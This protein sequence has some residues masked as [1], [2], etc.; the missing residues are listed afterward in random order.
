[1]RFKWETS[2]PF[3]MAALEA[4]IQ[5]R[6]LGFWMAGSGPAMTKVENT[7]Q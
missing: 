6:K 5:G 2:I 7:G 3:V 1:M 4:A